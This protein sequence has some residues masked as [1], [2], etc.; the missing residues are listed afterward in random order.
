MEK[1]R[2]VKTLGRGSFGAAILVRRVTDDARFV[3]K[4]IDTSR[5][6]SKEKHEV[7][8]EIDV[9]SHLDSPCIVQYHEH[10]VHKKGMC[11]VME[12]ADGG[13]LS[14]QV[15]NAKKAGRY[16]SEEAILNWFVQI[17]MGLKHC[18]D[19][20]ILHRDLKTQNIFLT[21]TGLVKL[22]DF[23]IAR[24]LL[25]TAE[26]ASTVVGTPYYLSPEIVENKKYNA[27]S[28]IWSLGVVLYELAALQ[29]PFTGSNLPQLVV[30]IT[31]GQFPPPPVH[32]SKQLHEL[33]NTML[34]QDPSKRPTV[35]QLLRQPATANRIRAVFG[36]TMARD[37]MSHT[38]LHGK[39]HAPV[40]HKHK[41][42]LRVAPEPK[43]AAPEDAPCPMQDAEPTRAGFVGHKPKSPPAQQPDKSKSHKRR[44]AGMHGAKKVSSVQAGRV[45]TAPPEERHPVASRKSGLAEQE[46]NKAWW[47]K[48]PQA[49]AA[50]PKKF[51]T[52]GS[53]MRA[54]SRSPPST[55]SRA[56]SAS[57]SQ[58]R[59][60]SA[61]SSKSS[62]VPPGLSIDTRPRGGVQHS[63]EHSADV[64]K[65][66][67]KSRVVHSPKSIS[68]SRSAWSTAP[69]GIEQPVLSPAQRI[70]GSLGS[71][72]APQQEREPK[73]DVTAV[74]H[75]QRPASATG[76]SVGIDFSQVEQGTL[77]SNQIHFTFGSLNTAQILGTTAIMNTN[78][79][80]QTCTWKKEAHNFW[81]APPADCDLESEVMSDDEV[82]QAAGEE[83]STMYHT[84]STHATSNPEDAAKEDQQDLINM[85]QDY[86]ME[87]DG[88]DDVLVEGQEDQE[89]EL[90]VEAIEFDVQRMKNR[91]QSELGSTMYGAVKAVVEQAVKQADEDGMT[92]LEL[93]T[94]ISFQL[95]EVIGEDRPDLVVEMKHLVDLE[96]SLN[97]LAE[98]GD[99]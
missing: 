60:S 69:D 22:G 66:V 92:D 27:K 80:W 15:E 90:N 91:L 85:L 54:S 51:L 31:R 37:E 99:L 9:L 18:H 57:S 89:D 82:V 30:S 73:P 50:E 49:S 11:I 34:K 71:P 79:N 67:V 62:Y 44:P 93:E 7:Q 6:S 61:H 58:S 5:M 81:N 64:P 2:K 72:S 33:I 40:A 32:F 24:V 96:D 20:K 68:T 43:Q 45:Q 70:K 8:V 98:G 52:K 94:E 86:L 78:S 16:I 76:A 41:S 1:Y 56:S 13:D 35:S 21:S 74:F 87:S 48:S 53:G 83:Q 46:E 23:G 97:T 47:E 10:F 75:T 38:V 42:R 63:A 29:V 59:L 14:H 39:L 3:L 77:D 4:R 95:Y 36:A 28:D 25:A 55:Q 84:C 65:P 17:C 26:M 12:Y 88:E 19:R